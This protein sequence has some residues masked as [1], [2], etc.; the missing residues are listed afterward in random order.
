MKKIWQIGITEEKK[1]VFP[2]TGEL[3]VI[4]CNSTAPHILNDWTANT[5]KLIQT[6]AALK[7]FCALNNHIF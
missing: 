6:Y 5:T 3:I 2:E 4:N 7:I 1:S